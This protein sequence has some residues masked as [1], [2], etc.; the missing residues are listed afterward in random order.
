MKRSIEIDNEFAEAYEIAALAHSGLKNYDSSNFYLKRVFELKSDS[1]IGDYL[2]G[3]NYYHLGDFESSLAHFEKSIKLNPNN[4]ITYYELSNVYYSLN[5]L[6][7]T[8]ENLKKA[9]ELGH[10]QA[11]EELEEYCNTD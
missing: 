10:Q 3:L 6:E 8:C 11:H 1:K 7:K 4:A 5:N 9:A 2:F